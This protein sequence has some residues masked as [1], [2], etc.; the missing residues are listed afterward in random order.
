[1]DI[2]I[3]KFQY[4]D[5]QHIE[6]LVNNF[7]DYLADI[8]NLKML[9][10]FD[11]K[12]GKEYTAIVLEKVKKEQGCSFVAL[13]SDT[14]IGFV[15]GMLEEQTRASELEVGK[16]KYGTVAELFVDE[17]YQRKGVGKQLMEKMEE[18]LKSK[19]CEI[20]STEVFAPNK[21]AYEFYKKSGYVDRSIELVK[22]V[23]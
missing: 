21:Q 20:I 4:A 13:D 11:G 15:M 22:F 14:I 23:R 6:Q 8:D 5:L 16:T 7:E 19:G 2:Q 12:S 3:R 17:K 18:Y 9:R 1:M 10:R